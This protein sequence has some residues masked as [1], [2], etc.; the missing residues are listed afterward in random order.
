MEIKRNWWFRLRMAIHHLTHHHV[1]LQVSGG[2]ITLQF[3]YLRPVARSASLVAEFPGQGLD[4]VIK[5]RV[6][7]HEIEAILANRSPLEMR[8]YLIATGG[9][10]VKR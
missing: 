7:T 3:C 6:Y 4:P 8:R 5:A 2:S 10:G 9:E 1:D